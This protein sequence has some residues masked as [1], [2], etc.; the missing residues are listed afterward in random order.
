MG[1][2][3]HGL[4]YP[5]PTDLPIGVDDTPQIDLLAEDI[6][7]A[8]NGLIADTGSVIQGVPVSPAAGWELLLAEYRLIGKDMTLHVWLKRTGAAITA[9][10]TGN[11]AGD[12]P[13]FTVT[14]AGL[15]PSLDQV[16]GQFRTSFTGGAYMLTSAGVASIYDMHASSTIAAPTSETYHT[17]QA[18]CNYPI[19]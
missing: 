14:D 3:A 4:R 10:T 1:V 15:R 9:G 2:T 19:P 7:T 18:Y 5:E 12:P 13:I 8:L 11:I 6:D 17:L 16:V